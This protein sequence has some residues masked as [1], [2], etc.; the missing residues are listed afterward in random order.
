VE[1]PSQRAVDVGLVAESAEAAAV[2]TPAAEAEE[3][4]AALPAGPAAE[5]AAPAA[6]E[7]AAFREPEAGASSSRASARAS[8][9]DAAPPSPP[10]AAVAAA[11]AAEDKVQVVSPVGAANPGRLKR[12]SWVAQRS[13][14]VEEDGTSA[15]VEEARVVVA[16]AGGFKDF[17]EVWGSRASTGFAGKQSDLLKS[18]RSKSEAEAALQRL[19]AGG[20]QDY[21]EIRNM[22]KLINELS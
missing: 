22:R 4:F 20:C 21:D 10:E 3:C 17:R 14:A 15:A 7:D 2:A 11:P 12:D 9:A 19:V 18:K 16:S 5:E 1:D 6:A 13:P 8:S